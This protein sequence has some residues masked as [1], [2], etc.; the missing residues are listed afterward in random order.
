MRLAAADRA[1]YPR[2]IVIEAGRPGSGSPGMSPER[3]RRAYSP[4]G[5]CGARLRRNPARPA[6]G[7]AGSAPVGTAGR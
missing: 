6:P 2:L 1:V 4:G 3:D 7:A 5:G